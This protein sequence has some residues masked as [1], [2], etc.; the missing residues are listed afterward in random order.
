MGAAHTLDLTS[1][2][3]HLIG[4]SCDS[5]KYAYVARSRPDVRVLQPAWVEAVRQAWLAGGDANVAALEAEHRLP[6]LFGLRL[7]LT[8]FEDVA[9]RQALAD[10]AAAHG[11]EYAGDLTKATTHLIAA[12][13][14]GRKYEFARQW[15]VRVVALDWLHA[16]IARGMVLDESKYD[17]LLD[18]AERGVGAFCPVPGPEPEVRRDGDGV[19]YSAGRTGR[20][21]LRRTASS[22]LESQNSEIWAEIADDVESRPQDAS[23]ELSRRTSLEVG[24]NGSTD[25][26]KRVSVDASG[27]PKS[28]KTSTSLFQGQVVL[29]YGFS[30]AKVSNCGC[31]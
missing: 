1:H 7:C 24:M 6:A 31:Q 19:G 14:A 20:K 26:V 2:V 8:G 29:V 21:R 23:L 11:G 10:L 25:G 15:G 30:A 16:S 3:T 9:Q 28:V 18:A 27:S 5:A 13:P 22:K 4:G 12:A 17:P